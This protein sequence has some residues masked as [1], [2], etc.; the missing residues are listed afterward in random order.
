MHLLTGHAGFFN[1]RRWRAGHL[2]HNRIK[3]ILCQEDTYLLELARYIY[4]NAIRAKLIKDSD[5]LREY[6][7]S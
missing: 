4:L 6:P 7:Y 5:L 2:F 1:I 3:S